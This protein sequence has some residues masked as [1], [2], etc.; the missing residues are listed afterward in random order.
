MFSKTGGLVNG[1][2]KICKFTE[3]IGFSQLVC[4][5]PGKETAWRSTLVLEQ[6]SDTD[7]RNYSFQKA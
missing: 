3:K 2:G 5:I 6:I 7:L 1:N 4:R